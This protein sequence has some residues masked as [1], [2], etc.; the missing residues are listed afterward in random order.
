[1]HAAARFNHGLPSRDSLLIFADSVRAGLTLFDTDTTYFA[2]VRRLFAILRAARANFPND[3]EISFALGDAYFH[4]GSGPGLSIDEDTML[5]A[6]DRTI[7]LDSGFTPAYIH[8]L[9]LRLARDGRDSGVRYAQAYLALRPNDDWADA[10]QVLTDAMRDGGISARSARILDTLSE[11]VVQTAW[12]MSRRWTDSSQTN[13]RLLQSL[14][15]RQS[16]VY[17][18]DPGIRRILLTGELA[19]RGHLQDAY[20]TLG[21]NIGIVEAE[22][23]G[24]LAFFGV[25]PHDTAAAVFARW[26]HDPAMWVAFALPWWAVQRDTL[27]LLAAVVK[28]DNAVPKAA[29]PV[30]RRAATY[31]AAAARAYLSL[32]RRSADAMKQFLQLPDT[33]CPGCPLDRYVKATL[34]D[35]LG[36]HDDAER[37]LLERPYLLLGSLEVFTAWKRANIAERLKHYATAARDYALVARAWSA[38]D[39][40]QRALAVQAAAKVELLGGDQQRPVTLSRVGR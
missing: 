3:P 14:A 15:G 11:D 6:F 5:A 25:V 9:E 22:A 7:Q 16:D 17:I 34:L 2:S 40:P 30:R 23:F 20:T 33:L 4:Y 26:L 29:T 32:G 35:S 39:P 18:A 12:M 21:T 13:V 28:I 8:A 38:G 31:R 36:R 19:Y 10:I 37:A 24:D 27:S 1:L